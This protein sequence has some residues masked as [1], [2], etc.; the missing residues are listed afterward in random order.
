VIIGS[1]VAAALLLPVAA[2]RI[3]ATAIEHRVASRL[4][5]AADLA[6]A[7]HVELGGFSALTQLASRSFGE[8]RVTAD[9]VKL[10]KVT[11]GHVEVDAERVSLADDGVAAGAVTVDATVPYSALTGLAAGAP[12]GSAMRITGADDA[13][14]LVVQADL[15][16]R[17]MSIPATVYADVALSGSRLT[18]T[19]AEVELSALGLRVPASRLPAAA[20]QP[21]TTD[22]PA[23]PAGLT[24]RSVTPTP[25]G[26]R[27]TAAGSELH[28]T[29][30]STNRKTCGGT[31]K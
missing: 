4:R 11:V 20:A 16:L 7:P 22:L 3:A 21:R 26:L 25:D 17:G 29:P 31:A 12:A 2:D 8:I 19:P 27:I 6:T 9:D 1:A 13:R 14:R 24:Y 15:A 23:L 18:V 30:H 28:L 10:P 5:C